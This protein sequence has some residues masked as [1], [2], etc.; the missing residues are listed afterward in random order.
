MGV[1]CNFPGFDVVNLMGFRCFPWHY[2]MQNRMG[3]NTTMVFY[4]SYE[5]VVNEFQWH[6]LASRRSLEG[7]TNPRFISKQL[8]SLH[9]IATTHHNSTQQLSLHSHF[10]WLLPEA[11]IH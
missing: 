9:T 6:S 4:E 10:T 5:I 2:F 1:L 7:S 11:R 3:L 8:S